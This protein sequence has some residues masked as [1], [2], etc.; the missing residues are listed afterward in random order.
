MFQ[1]WLPIHFSEE[2]IKAIPAQDYMTPESFHLAQQMM[3]EELALEFSGKPV[4]PH[5]S[6]T[7]ELEIYHKGGGT[8]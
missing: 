4:D 5:R 8:V 2:P 1:N 3:A 7:V 6:R